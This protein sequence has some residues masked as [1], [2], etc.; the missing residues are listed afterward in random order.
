MLR[1]GRTLVLFAAFAALEADA[2]STSQPC[3]E[4]RVYAS[5]INARTHVV[6]GLGAQDFSAQ[7]NGKPTPIKSVEQNRSQHRVVI[8]IDHSGSMRGKWEAV[9]QA[10]LDILQKLP[11][12]T[13][14]SVAIFDEKVRDLVPLTRNRQAAIDAVEQF[15]AANRPKS[16]RTR[17]FDTLDA[18]LS[19]L[20]PSVSGD[21]LYAIT[22]GGDNLS[23][24]DKSRLEKQLIMSRARFFVA[25]LTVAQ[26]STHEEI[27]GPK[28]LADLASKTGGTYFQLSFV[29]DFKLTRDQI[30]RLAQGTQ[31][32]AQN[33]IDD[34]QI[35]LTLAGTIPTK[36]KIKL[37]VRIPGMEKDK[38][39]VLTKPLVLTDCP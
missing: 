20:G 30:S 14:T 4:L 19:S 9:H 5:V 18:A 2:Q 26:P 32:L 34:Y 31:W 1:F 10:A 17:L 22:D 15:F 13:S 7:L 24:N 35:T 38:F 25:L 16:T 21:T 29:D 37:N 36:A 28:S 23:V 8:L 3:N 6:A 11:P 27:D 33:I 39:Q 12:Q